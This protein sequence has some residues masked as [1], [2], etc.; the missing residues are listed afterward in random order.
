LRPSN[1]LYATTAAPGKTVNLNLGTFGFDSTIPAN[2]TI[3]GV[4]VS[5]EWKVSTTSSIATL[6]A[7]AYVN[8][9]PVGTELVNTAEPTGDTTQTFTVPGLTRAQLLNGTFG[10]RV[11]ATRGNSN[12]AFTAS[13]D[14]VSVTVDYTVPG[15]M[16]MTTNA[17]GNLVAKGADTFAYDV[18]NRLTGATVASAG[19]TAAPT[20]ASDRWALVGPIPTTPGCAR[21]ATARATCCSSGP[22]GTPIGLLAV[23][24]RSRPRRRPT[25]RS[26]ATRISRTR[27][28]RR[29]ASA[30]RSMRPA[31]SRRSLIGTATPQ[32]CRTTHRAS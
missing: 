4:T 2:A 18:A 27:S 3:T 24:D 14:A 11:R 30:G 32:T 15:N 26:F 23:A 21:R 29:T 31:S 19:A 20:R 16:T 25:P 22:T 10:V 17:N 7:R 13:L 1:N 6:G 12:T 9:S 28:P 5:V 8:G